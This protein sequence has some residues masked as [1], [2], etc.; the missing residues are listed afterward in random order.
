MKNQ[1][2]FFMQVRLR[3]LKRHYDLLLIYRWLK[4]DTG[5][6]PNGIVVVNLNTQGEI[7]RPWC[8]NVTIYLKTGYEEEGWFMGGHWSMPTNS[9]NRVART[10]K[11]LYLSLR[12]N[13]VENLPGDFEFELQ[14][15]YL[16]YRNASQ[17]VNG[18]WFYNTRECEDVANLFTRVGRQVVN[19]PSFMVRVDS[20]KHIDYLLTCPFGGGRRGRVKRKN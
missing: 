14:V 3:W 12:E 9:N 4:G 13:L 18:I 15:P 10:L 1:H 19:V 7:P 11:G 20:Q 16:L 6:D 17:E 8:P 2:F 5:R